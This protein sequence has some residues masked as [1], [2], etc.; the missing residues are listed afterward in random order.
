M[1]KVADRLDTIEEK[2]MSGLKDF[3]K[4]TVER[5]DY[6]YQHKQRRVLVSDEVGLGKTLIARGTVAKL[7][8]LRREE[9]D[10]LVKVVYICSNA[11][12]ADQNLRKLRV[13]HELKTE[14][15]SSSRLS[16]QHLNIFKQENDSDL[17]D[18]Y[19]Q[20]IP[21][22]PETSFRMTAGAGTV[23][24]RALMFAHLKRMPELHSYLYE[25]EVAMMDWATS[26]W[27]SWCR[28]WYEEEA[29]SCNEGSDGRYF[30]YMQYHLHKELSAIWRDDLTFMD[31]L[32]A[33]CRAIRRNKGE[34]VGN[35]A[36]IGQL[37]VI[38]AKISLEKLEP[39]LVIMDEFQRF[40]Y[41]LNSDPESET[42]MLANKFFH[43][44]DVRMLLLSATPYKM[45]S[46]PEEIDETRLDEH[47]TEFLSVMK[48]LNEDP[49]AEN[50]FL[51][52]WRDYSIRLKELTIGD[53]TILSAKD[54][55][56]DA[57]YQ[58][59]CRTERI[60]ASENAD[61]IDDTD[62]AIPLEVLEQDI[63]SY[64]QAQQLLD[65]I[66]ANYHV[67]VDYIKSTPYLM[68][69]MRDYQLKRN[70]EKYFKAHP[71]EIRKIKKD[72]FWLKRI[73][74]DRYDRIPNNN[75]RL[76]RVMDKV[77][78]RGVEKLLWM[79]PSKPYYEMEGVYKNTAFSSKTLIFSAWEMVPRMLASLISYEAERRT[80]GKLAK[81]YEDRDVHYFYSGEKRYPSAR[82]N[83]SVRN[84]LPGAMT[85]FCLL[86][87]S[88][89]LTEC[90][91][92]ISCMNAKKS[93]K[94]IKKL[95]RSKIDEKLQEMPSNRRGNQDARWYYMA[96][97]MM[98]GAKYSYTWLE[99][100]DQ[101]AD[102]D[103]GDER[104]KRKKGFKTH[105]NA[106]LE[107]FHETHREKFENLGRRPDDLA[108]VLTDMAIASPACL[109][110][111]PASW[112]G[113]LLIG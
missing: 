29:V 80:V 65:E 91:D 19:I 44:R 51:T 57:M 82:M 23:S 18:R 39:D 42:G 6:L 38:F 2:I 22:T 20:L 106:L 99:S 88:R 90:Y 103:D 74:L 15:T 84:G 98:D 81:D 79:P 21:L 53:T 45:Y 73:Q 58:T 96:P 56:E 107:L 13:T 76:E 85:L 25:L 41:L 83:F 50:H 109:L 16:M 55:A 61:I 11:A 27:N 59:V 111:C 3:Q 92:P 62:V 8:K 95:V 78:Q 40:K 24:E 89:F 9:G 10:D 64:V 32:I 101:L 71:E 31:G 63:R 17:L 14:S 1:A 75:A 37:R 94:D 77:L 105:L 113:F 69:F 97:L 12:I 47:Y 46:T 49:D 28:D 35:N 112:Q 110:I 7:A 60:S 4:A 86:Y 43:A 26:S 36:I 87:P 30:E 100:G 108:D 72:S 66:G 93:I 67:P 102:Y 54:A 104:A 52:V 48:F 34:R 5:I 70:V 33:L 68:S